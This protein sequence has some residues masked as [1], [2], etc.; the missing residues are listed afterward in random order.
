MNQDTVRREIHTPGA[1]LH[2][3]ESAD[4]AASSRDIEGYAIL[5]DTPSAPLLS[6]SQTEIREVIDPSAVTRELLDSSDI[7][8]TL[9]HDGQLLLARSKQGKGTL[10]YSI[11]ERGVRFSFTA[12][13]TADGDKAVELVRSGIIDGCSFAFSTRYRDSAYVERTVER[14][15]GK[16]HI[17]CRVKVIT[18]IYDMTLTPDPAYEDTEC[19]VRDIIKAGEKERKERELKLKAYVA[20]MRG[21]ARFGGTGRH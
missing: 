5:F 11:D 3:R 9:F 6:D 8:M 17:T 2:I 4:G 16:D 19:S 20:E 12:P 13:A 18:G 14:K 7:K 15:D 21:N 1:G 10:S